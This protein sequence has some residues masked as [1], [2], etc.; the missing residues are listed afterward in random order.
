MVH[1]CIYYELNDSIWSDFEYDTKA[2]YLKQLAKQHP[3]EAKLAKYVNDFKEWEE[4]EHYVSGY[5]LIYKNNDVDP[6]IL[7]KAR[8]I[9]LYEHKIRKNEMTKFRIKGKIYTFIEDIPVNDDVIKYKKLVRNSKKE[10]FILVHSTLGYFL[11][12]QN[13]KRILKTNSIQELQINK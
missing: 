5:N 9:L 12:D 4:D 2:K 10:L 8:E 13:E 6:F 11:Y 7:R 3:E 1:S